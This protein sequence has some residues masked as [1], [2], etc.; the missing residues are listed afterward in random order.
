ML[1][2]NTTLMSITAGTTAVQGKEE[3]A[4]GEEQ[5]DEQAIEVSNQ[6]LLGYLQVL[7]KGLHLPEP[8]APGGGG[9]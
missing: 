3:E 2:I 1:V 4:I 7:Q 6:V 5:V 9:R 8:K